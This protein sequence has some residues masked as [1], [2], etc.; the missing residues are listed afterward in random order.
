MQWKGP[1]VVR[2]KLNRVDY[3]I[4]VNGK[5]KTFHIN[6]LKQYEERDPEDGNLLSLVTAE[7]IDDE[8]PIEYFSHSSMLTLTLISRRVNKNAPKSFTLV[9]RCIH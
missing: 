8:Q 3:E 1:F 6:L 5:R 7:T 2:N 9:Y 4:E